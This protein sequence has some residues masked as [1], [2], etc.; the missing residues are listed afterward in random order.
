RSG[1]TI[2]VS[3]QTASFPVS[4]QGCVTAMVNDASGSPLRDSGVDFVVTGVDSVISN[5]R[6]DVNG[7]ANFCYIGKAAGSDLVKAAIGSATSS[8]TINWT[9][10]GPNQAPVVNTGA[11][12]T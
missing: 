8:A 2:S 7:Q 9:S 6:T 1:T 10:N 12:Q 4:S 3:P 5:V 11:N